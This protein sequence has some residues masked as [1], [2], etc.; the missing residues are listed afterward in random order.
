MVLAADLEGEND[1]DE[2]EDD[3]DETN[4]DVA[5]LVDVNDV[6]GSADILE[7]DGEAMQLLERRFG[8][9]I[10]EDVLNEKGGTYE[11]GEKRANDPKYNFCP[12][13]HRMGVMHIVTRHFVQH[14]IFPQRGGEQW[15]AKRIYCKSVYEAYTYCFQ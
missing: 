12:A 10:E 11:E 6:D 9:G 5:P 2:P 1:P 14:P 8:K 13:V 7:E 15:D 3:V 4:E